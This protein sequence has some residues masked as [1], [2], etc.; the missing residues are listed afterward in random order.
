VEA[1]V[2]IH[3]DF[4]DPSVDMCTEQVRAALR[5]QICESIGGNVVCVTLDSNLEKRLRTANETPLTIEEQERLRDS[6]GRELGC[7]MSSVK[8]IIVTNRPI[9]RTLYHL[10]SIEFPNLTVLSYDEFLPEA[11]LYPIGCVTL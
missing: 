5:G 11:T 2:D 4:R 7:P 10:L 6:A 9:R 3:V 1:L 8:G